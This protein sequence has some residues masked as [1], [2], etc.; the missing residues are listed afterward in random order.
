MDLLVGLIGGFLIGFTSTGLARLYR[1]FHKMKSPHPIAATKENLSVSVYI[2]EG[3]V[4][5]YSL[6]QPDR[7]AI[8]YGW[9]LLTG[10]E[11]APDE[12]ILWD[13]FVRDRYRRRGYGRRLIGALQ[14]R[15][16]RILTQYE[17]GVVNSAGVRLCLACGFQMKPALFKNHPPWL[18]WE[19]K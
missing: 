8:P 16:R 7:K 10:D 12:A 14:S 2:P 13:I 15:Y 5:V 11:N 19:R 17:K 4:A 6:H 3:R 9:A 18:I 1:R